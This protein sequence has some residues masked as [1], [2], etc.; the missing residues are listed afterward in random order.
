MQTFLPYKDFDRTFSVL[1]YKRLG[2]QRVEA[3]QII[4]ILEGKAKSNAW[5]NHPAVRMWKG[6]VSALKLYYNRCIWEWVKRG[7]KNNMPILDIIGRIEFPYWLGDEKFH[8]S[9]RSN[10]L[11][12]DKEYYSK[13]FKERDDL[14]YIWPKQVEV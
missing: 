12:K 8:R 1:D 11:R 3:K 7:Y 6:Y 10:L 4:D 14:E 9:H 2:K 13:Y 5:K